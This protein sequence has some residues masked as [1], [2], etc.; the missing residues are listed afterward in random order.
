M[1]IWWVRFICLT[2]LPIFYPTMVHAQDSSNLSQKNS[3]PS[4]TFT[5]LAAQLFSQ[6]TAQHLSQGEVLINLDTRTFLFPDLVSGGVDN[7]DS[8][9]NFNTGFSW[10]INDNLQ[11]TLQ[12]Q[13][14]DSSSPVKQGGFI[15]ERTE[16]NEAVMELKHNLWSNEAQTQ[17][18]SGVIA[19]SWGTRGFMF[20]RGGEETEINNRDVF[21]SLA[22]PFTTSM[23][24]R[25]QF[26]VSPTVAFFKDE[27]AVFFHR[28]P[29]DEDSFFGTVLGLGAGVSYRANSRLFLVSDVFVPVTGNNSINRDSGSPDKAIAYNAGLRFFTNPRLALDLYA[30]NTFARFAP[31][32]LTADRDFLGLGAN[33]VFMPDAISANQKYSDLFS[34]TSQVESLT[35]D[36]LAFFDGGTIPSGDFSLQL[37]GG[38]QGVLT[39]LRYGFLPDFTGGI[40]L[41]YIGGNVDESEQGISGK[42]RFLSQGNNA[43]LTISGAATASLT[44]EV[45]INFF[46]NDSNAF[47]DSNF[48]KTIPIFTPGGDNGDR[49]ELLILTLALPVHYEIDRGTAVWFTPILGYV[50]RLGLEIGGFNLGSAIALS[51][52]IRLMGEVGANLG[53]EGNSLVDGRRENK[54]P[55]N[56]GVRWLPLSLLNREASNNNSDPYLELYLTNRVGA[57]TWHQL[58]VRED[59]NIGVGAGLFLPF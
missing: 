44:N 6:P 5:P 31:L 57:S 55:W 23:G 40:F 30:T 45:L 19:A 33:L 28:L 12:F 35:T 58:R 48:N 59:N 37:Q 26:T 38:S 56:I 8:A 41:D 51:E 11:L 16:D 54:I 9:V 29:D 10:G 13:H 39:A 22:V 50:Q 15:S 21:V 18:L 36:G 46:E 17:K 25:W 27:S 24:D 2:I 7:E 4:I 43:P 52:E 53:G 49:R 32:S 47:E 42:V 20:T 34:D 14:V 1:K 3:P